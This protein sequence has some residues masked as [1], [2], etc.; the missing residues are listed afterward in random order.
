MW[1][2]RLPIPHGDLFGYPRHSVW[3]PAD[4]QRHLG[5]WVEGVGPKMIL[6][7]K[8]LAS[9]IALAASLL[10]SGCIMMPIPYKGYPHKSVIG[11]V[12]DAETQ[13]PIADAKVTM[14]LYGSKSNKPFKELVYT[15]SDSSGFFAGRARRTEKRPVYIVFPLLPFTSNYR[16]LQF[17]LLV[18]MPGYSTVEVQWPGMEH[19]GWLGLNPF[20]FEKEIYLEPIQLARGRSIDHTVYKIKAPHK[21]DKRMFWNPPEELEVLPVESARTSE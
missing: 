3:N 8:T 4:R 21:R 15:T 11:Q 16:Y 9:C 14:G 20:L 13:E 5:G 17:R 18:E 6:R 7:E 2:G 1:M 12:L 19:S 10:F